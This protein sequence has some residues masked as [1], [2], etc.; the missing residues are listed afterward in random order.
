MLLA[1]K[2]LSCPCWKNLDHLKEKNVSDFFFTE[3]ITL[4]L[5]QHK[6]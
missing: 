1:L 4:L 2:K 5:K 3:I 6:C